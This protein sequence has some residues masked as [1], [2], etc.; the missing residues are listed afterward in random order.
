MFRYVL[1][2]YSHFIS[3]KDDEVDRVDSTF[4]QEMMQEKERIAEEMKALESNAQ[5]LEGTLE[6][7]KTG[8]SE[9]EVLEKEKNMLELDVKKFRDMIEQLEGRKVAMSKLLEEKEKGLEVK[10]TEKENICV[11]NEDL[12]KRVEEQGINAR[13]AERM[14]RELQALEGNIAEIEA[15]R[16]KWEEKVWELDSMIGQKYEKLEELMIGCNQAIRRY[17]FII[18]QHPFE[19]KYF[20]E[21]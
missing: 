7:L 3:G 2:S 21:E 13:D 19:Y 15:A 6:R 12:K 1:E 17:L 5:E 18:H 4:M 20:L 8:P 10:N 11:E 14:K 16:N 9:R